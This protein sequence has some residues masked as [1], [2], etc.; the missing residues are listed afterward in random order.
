MNQ[1]VYSSTFNSSLLVAPTDIMNLAVGGGFSRDI[2]AYDELASDL[3]P[4]ACI[5]RR[6]VDGAIFRLE[7]GRHMPTSGLRR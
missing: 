7:D 4:P 1:S 3:P 6:S 5:Y 2:E